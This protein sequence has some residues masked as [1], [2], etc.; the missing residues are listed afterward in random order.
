MDYRKKLTILITVGFLLFFAPPLWA[1]DYAVDLSGV[2]SEDDLYDLTEWE[3]DYDEEEWVYAGG[4]ISEE[5]Y[6]LLRDLFNNPVDLNTASR[7]ELYNLPAMTYPLADRIIAYRERYGPFEKPEDIKK[8][9]GVEDIY[10]Q[11]EPFATVEKKRKKEERGWKGESRFKFKNTE[12]D[13]ER[14]YMYERLRLHAYDRVH[15]G[16]L[17][18]RD[19]ILDGYTATGSTAIIKNEDTE[20]RLLRKYIYMAEPQWSAIVGD[21]GVGF[22]QGLVFNET[23]R[24]KAHGIY[25]NDATT[26]RLL[27]AAF[28]WKKIPLG[29][30]W[31]DTTV[32]YSQDDYDLPSVS[33]NRTSKTLPDVY[34]EELEGANVTF[35]WDK[36]THL[37]A[38][39]YQ[40]KIDRDFPFEYKSSYW[41]RFPD[42]RTFSV[43][44]LDFATK[45]K[46]TNLFAEFGRRKDGG[47][48]YLLKALTELE[49]FKLETIY[50]DYDTDFEN[51]HSKSFGRDT[52]EKGYRIKGD[53]KF[54][55]RWKVQGYYKQ[56]KQHS[57]LVTDDEWRGKI[58]YSP[59]KKINLSYYRKWRNN[60]IDRGGRSRSSTEG[61][62]ITDNFKCKYRPIKRLRLETSYTFKQKDASKYTNKFQE[63]QTAYFKVRYDLPKPK[64]LTLEGRMKYWDTDIHSGR[65]TR[66]QEYYLQA[67]EKF[68]KDVKLRVRYTYKNY[69]D[70]GR[71]PAEDEPKKTVFVQLDIKW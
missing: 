54:S 61:E 43:A 63:D 32:F 13:G 60:D 39:W 67:T 28:R 10:P 21:Y 55:R 19:E 34:R 53:Y 38:T 25:Y 23:G 18:E 51:P 4:D 3:Y 64:G 40:S 41:T 52:D 22:G 12:K 14:P 62:T 5:D 27:G 70:E 44:G 59:I 30:R 69:T 24:S 57:T 36:K 31:L 56:W 66:Y 49:R 47:D 17:L 8:V 35:W 11:I 50:Y 45:I 46:R 15:L 20:V 9:P 65:G 29:K 33:T 58:D 7:K 71:S 48:A 1:Y 37:G 42:K 6:E 16:F 2:E 26:D 68:T